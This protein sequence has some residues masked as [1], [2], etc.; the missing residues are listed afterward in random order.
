[1]EEIKRILVV[2]RSTQ[3]GKK[4]LHYGIVLAKKFGAEIVVIHSIHNPFGL[5]GWNLPIPFL[6]EMEKE[7]KKMQEEVRSGL[8]KMIAQEQAAGLPIKVIVSEGEPNQDIFKTVKEEKIDLLIL[9]CHKEGHL[10]HLLFGR[11]NDE[12]IRKI[13]CSI[14][15][16]EDEPKPV[17]W[18]S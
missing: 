15:L 1:M 17:H 2:N 12:I 3:H 9:R 11:S 14:L 7:Y 8:D 13:P 18:T 6:P 10:E 5:E 4:A 16:V